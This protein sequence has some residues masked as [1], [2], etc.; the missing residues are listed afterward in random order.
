MSERA[1]V[2]MVVPTA[3]DSV[4][5]TVEDASEMAGSLSLMESTS[6]RTEM[7][8]LSPSWSVACTIICRE[9][10]GIRRGAE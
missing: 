3:V 1:Q 9:T 10:V 8:A 6:T 5:L 2:E 7:Y 4:K